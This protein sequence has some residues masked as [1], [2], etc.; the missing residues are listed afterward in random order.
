MMPRAV[1]TAN[2]TP[3]AASGRLGRAVTAA[4]RGRNR[5]AAGH[6]RPTLDAVSKRAMCVSPTT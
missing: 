4:T 2:S 6:S 5:N 1:H 3:T